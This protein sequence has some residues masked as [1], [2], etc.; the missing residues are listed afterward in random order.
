MHLLLFPVLFVAFRIALE[1][2][3]SGSV[4]F[5]VLQSNPK[6][7]QVSTNAVALIA[8]LATYEANQVS[9]TVV[10]NPF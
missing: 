7:L 8:N 5:K 9:E 3:T 1:D 4:I 10:C 2:T 6:N